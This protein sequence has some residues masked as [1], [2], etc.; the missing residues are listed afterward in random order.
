ML[1]LAAKCVAR[2]GR[3]PGDSPMECTCASPAS[4][5]FSADLRTPLDAGSAEVLSPVCPLPQP[6]LALC[7]RSR[8]ARG[9]SFDWVVAA[10]NSGAEPITSAVNAKCAFADLLRRRCR[11][12][13]LLLL[14]ACYV[15]ACAIA[16]YI[17]CVT[18]ACRCLSKFLW[19]A[20]TPSRSHL[21]R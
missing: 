8:P 15:Q 17:R 6:E 7:Q 2:L 11:A 14:A 18:V 13:R 9:G 1:Q 12:L 4:P 10:V 21:W 16:C 5:G 20:S 19:Q 3:M